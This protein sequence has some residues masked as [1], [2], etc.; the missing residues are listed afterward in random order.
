MAAEA[1]THYLPAP[2]AEQK[3]AAWLDASPPAPLGELLF[4]NMEGVAFDKFVALPVL[5]AKLREK[6]GVEVRMSGSGSACFA[7]IGEATPEVAT[8]LIARMTVMIRDSWGEAVFVQEA[9]LS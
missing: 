5:L 2:Q 6:F 3:L 9:R 1:P 8:D 7:V 4:N